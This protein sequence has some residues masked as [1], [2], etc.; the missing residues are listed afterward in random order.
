VRGCGC[1]L[2]AVVLFLA[3]F[4]VGSVMAHAW[5]W[6]GADM[7]YACR[8]GLTTAVTAAGATAPATSSQGAWK[9]RTTRSWG[10]SGR[11]NPDTRGLGRL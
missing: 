5:A 8:K 3:L 9:V 6:E 1:L 2:L 10:L 11:H 4:I 7:R